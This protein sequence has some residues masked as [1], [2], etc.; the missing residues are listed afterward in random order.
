MVAFLG[1][2]RSPVVLQKLLDRDP[3]V[4]LFL[5]RTPPSVVGGKRRT[6]SLIAESN[7]GGEQPP[8]AFIP[9]ANANPVIIRWR[10]PVPISSAVH[11]L[12]VLHANNVVH[13]TF[14]ARVPS[15][16]TGVSIVTVVVRGANAIVLNCAPGSPSKLDQV[17][18]DIPHNPFAGR[19]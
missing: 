15:W 13:G 18:E 14:C 2:P 4:R 5:P 7:P 9:S 6:R 3:V 19:A 17:S 11:V 16:S 8:D 1:C 12:Q 10:E